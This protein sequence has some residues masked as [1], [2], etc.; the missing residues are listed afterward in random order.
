MPLTDDVPVR[1]RTNTRAEA[2]EERRR[3]IL[4]AAAAAF[5]EAGYNATSLREVA[6]RAGLSHTGLL[7]H[8]PDKPGLLEAVLDDRIAQA[9]A[10]FPL[11]SADGETFLRAL[12]QIAER[13]GKQPDHVRMFA[14]LSAEAL[15]PGHPAHGYMQRWFDRVRSRLTAALIEM[16]TR[17]RYRGRP[18]PPEQAAI[19]ISAMRDGTTLQ[20]LLARDRIDFAGTIRAQIL[21]YVDIDL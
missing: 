12:V 18:V 14:M 7:H 15:T 4:R 16:E 11:E 19:H 5:G 2:T 10:E 3:Q 20:W 21:A 1:R 6:A 9:A 17:G 13:D 8:F